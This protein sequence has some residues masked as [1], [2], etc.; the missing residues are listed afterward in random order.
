MEIKKLNSTTIEVKES[1]VYEYSR[2][3]DKK[4]ILENFI[5]EYK[6]N[7]DLQLSVLPEQL[8]LNETNI[9]LAECAK[10]DVKA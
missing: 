7:F 9:L 5:I 4:T 8:E 2:L 3:L 6:K 10:L 1:K